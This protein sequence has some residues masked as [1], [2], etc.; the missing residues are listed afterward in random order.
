MKLAIVILQNVPSQL[1]PT[2]LKCST[3]TNIFN[4]FIIINMIN[5]LYFGRKIKDA[6]TYS[7]AGNSLS[8]DRSL[9]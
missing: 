2:A 4:M 7:T 5:T 8:D 3:L 1:V 6:H 9:F